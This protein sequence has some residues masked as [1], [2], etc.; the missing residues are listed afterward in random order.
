MRFM[1][2]MVRAAA[3]IAVVI[4]AATQFVRPA[5]AEDPDLLSFTTAYYDV[6]HR[7][8]PAAEV[9]IE[10]RNSERYWIFK[11]FGGMAGTSDFTGYVYAGILIDLYFGQHIVLT[12]SFAPGVWLKGDGKDLGYPIEFRSQIEMAYRFDDHSR[13]ALAYAHM[14]NGGLGDRNPGVEIASLTYI[15]PFNKLFGP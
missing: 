4:G 6:Y 8:D 9:A 3:I 10:Y 11:T 12:P 5:A 13:L 15:L 1:Q 7:K 14:S 2:A